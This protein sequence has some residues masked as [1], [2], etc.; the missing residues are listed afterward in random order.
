MPTETPDGFWIVLLKAIG[1]ALGLLTGFAYMTLIERRL[2][3]RFQLRHGPNRVGPLGLLQP[4]ADAIK[5]IF[6]EDILVTM[7]DKFVYFLAPLISVVFAIMAFSAIPAGPENSLFGADPWIVNLDVGILFVLAC[8]SMGV[9]GI[10][11]G[12]WAGGSKYPLMGGLRSSAQ[13]ISYEL[14]QGLSVLALIMI[15]G[16]MNFR[17][18]VAWQ[19]TNGVMVLF[20]SLGFATF[21]IAS[22]AETNR[23]PFDLPEAEQELVAGYLTE[24][25]SIK[26]ALFQM[27]EYI[28][29][30][31]ASAV[32]STLFF[33][34]F[35]GP[36]FLDAYIPGISDW[37][38]IWLMVKIGIFLFIFI[39]IRATV[40]RMRYDHLMR[41]GWK[42]LFP[43][44]LLNTMIAAGYLAFFPKQSPMVLGAI[45]LALLFFLIAYNTLVQGGQKPKALDDGKTP[46]LPQGGD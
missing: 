23:A 17:E 36:Q 24:Y 19:A 10:F 16:A 21:F 14:G 9:Y 3:G 38:F 39:W 44:G 30:F 20:Q 42:T 32:M 28:N 46:P 34:G 26:W 7:A 1:V 5:S 40:P 33:G 15:V 37:P 18:I 45:S 11:L 25:S 6:K 2:L 27:S 35:K 41:L 29:L 22:L 31:T 8:T 13:M 12:G 4:V 43:L